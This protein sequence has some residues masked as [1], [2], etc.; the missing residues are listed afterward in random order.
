MPGT[1][2]YRTFRIDRLKAPLLVSWQITRECD[3]SCLHC[4]TGS[5]PGKRLSDEL[6]A[7]EAQSVAEQLI[8]NEVPYVML[9]GGEPVMVPHFPA[10]AQQLGTA[11]VALKIETNGQRL[12][13]A[14]I[15]RLAE[16]PV[17]S[18]QISLDADSQSVYVA[19]RPGG[20]LQRA[21]T[22]CRNVHSAGLPLEVTFAPTRVNIH[23][24][25]PVIE[26]AAALGAFRFNTGQL[27]R[28]GTAAR[29]WQTLQP[30]AQQYRSFRDTLRRARGRAETMNMELSF[31]P[32]S[33]ADALRGSLDE[34]PATLLVLPNGWVKVSAA[35]PHICADLRRHTLQECWA[36]YRSA[37]RSPEIRTA[38]QAAIDDE[39]SHADSNAWRMTAVH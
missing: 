6:D 18:V 14:L 31:T 7:V 33:I 22:A 15:T 34:P 5:A 24:L 4:C 38:L 39:S 25:Q 2:A 13:E 32:F 27:M 10:L 21:H 8:S 35:L 3:L 28:M 9:C 20:S 17:R 16:L 11:G 30:T 37:W 19:Q 23:E 1:E 26:R 12:D 29:R 36:R